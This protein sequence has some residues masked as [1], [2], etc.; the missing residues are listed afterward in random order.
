MI[1]C[2]EEWEERG[3][4][5][6]EEEVAIIVANAAVEQREAEKCDSSESDNESESALQFEDI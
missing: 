6:V 2:L 3:S 5:L 4:L 1:T